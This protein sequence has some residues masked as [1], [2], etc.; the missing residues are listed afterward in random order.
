MAAWN[1]RQ[2]L[3]S[4]DDF[5]TVMKDVNEALL[6]TGVTTLFRDPKGALSL[7][8]LITFSFCLICVDN[9]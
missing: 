5:Q 7:V 8:P 9:F 1:I 6:Y 3:L 4:T 2:G